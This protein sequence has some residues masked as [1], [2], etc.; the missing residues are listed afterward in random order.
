MNI[1]IIHNLYKIHGGEEGVVDMQCRLFRERGHKVFTYLRDYKEINSWKGGKYRSLITSMYNREAAKSVD[2]LVKEN[3]I[4]VALIHNLYPIISPS[5][6]KV[7]KKNN[8]RTIW[9][10]HNYRLIC[11]TALL[12]NK[13]KICDKCTR[14]VRELNAIINCCEG[15]FLGSTA[16]AARSFWARATGMIRKNIDC[17]ITLSEFQCELFISHGVDSKKIEVINNT[18]TFPALNS[19]R[20]RNNSVLY[21]G[22][23]SAEKGIHIL[24]GAARLLPDVSFI[25][26]GDGEFLPEWGEIPKNIKCLGRVEREELIK[27]YQSSA[28]LAITSTFYET[29]ALTSIEAALSLCPTI[30]PR[31][32]IFIDRIKEGETGLFFKT[33]E[34]LARQ[35]KRL[36]DD[37]SLAKH[38]AKQ[39]QA[40]CIEEYNTTKYVD[41]FENVMKLK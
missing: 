7:L 15:T 21:A 14:G 18:T 26:A 41:R 28:L 34:E 4:E 10:A 8:V 39:C 33:E 35:I 2:K 12:Y 27:L 38:I 19:D 22:R 11:P 29:F 20:K 23:I 17:Y 37:K 1:L 25:V 5:V 3:K 13:G 30:Y 32:G 9:I 40:Y 6:L 31:L 24:L 16:Y 36:L